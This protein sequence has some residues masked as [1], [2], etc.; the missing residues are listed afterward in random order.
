M[1][2]SY[3]TV[4]IITMLLNWFATN[5]CFNLPPQCQIQPTVPRSENECF[6]D[7]Y[8]WFYNF[9]MKKC[10]TFFGRCPRGENNFKHYEECIQRCQNQESAC[11]QKEMRSDE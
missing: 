1:P 5:Q 3:D 10:V 2:R 11:F 4:I 6:A 8:R 7:F 9:D